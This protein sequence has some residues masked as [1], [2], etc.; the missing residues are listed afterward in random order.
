MSEAESPPGGA[1]AHDTPPQPPPPAAPSAWSTPP[2]ASDPL[3]QELS[4]PLYRAR[5]WLQF[6][7]VMAILSGV[8]QALTLVGIVVA[9]L[10]IWLGA[11][12]FQSAERID[13]AR[14]SG[15]R[16]DFEKAMDRLRLIFVI[17]GV[18]ALASIAL[19]ALVLM[20]FGLAGILGALSSLD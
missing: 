9:W 5:G 1:P 20:T 15:S 13:S 11:L 10:P 12:M 8:I 2:P 14:R 16:P 6:L 17:Q 18:T 3:V 7:G 19:A 4:W